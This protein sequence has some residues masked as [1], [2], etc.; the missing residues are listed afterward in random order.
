ML[1]SP[2]DAVPLPSFAWPFLFSCCSGLST[3]LG[4]VLVI[5]LSSPSSSSSQAP[6]SIGPPHLAFT[7]GLACAV[8]LFVSTVQMIIPAILLDGLLTTTVIA[9]TSALLTTATIQHFPIDRLLS[10]CGVAIASHLT[11]GG[12][13]EAVKDVDLES[14]ATSLEEAEEELAL[15][16]I[17]FSPSSAAQRRCHTPSS[18]ETSVVLSTLLLGE[19]GGSVLSPSTATSTLRVGLLTALLLALHNLPEGLAVFVSTVNSER[20]GLLMMLSICMHNIPEGL[21][22]ATPV[23]AST[24]STAQTLWWTALSGCTEPLGA[25]LALTLLRSWLTPVLIQRLL[26]GVAGMMIAVAVVEL[27]PSGRAYQQNGAMN[28]GI[29][30]GDRLH[31]LH[32]PRRRYAVTAIVAPSAQSSIDSESLSV[33]QSGYVSA[34]LSFVL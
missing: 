12:R 6:V 17:N 14:G 31:D 19:A 15:H 29:G 13:A 2:G 33:D 34:G 26:S 10:C 4:A 16:P 1:S 32:L 11:S 27:W 21:V 20:A 23:Y 7:S 8:M 18:A 3:V 28:A 9:L 22:I 5:A 25:V 30:V 24:H